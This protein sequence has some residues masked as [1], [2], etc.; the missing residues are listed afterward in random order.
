MDTNIIGS[1]HQWNQFDAISAPSPDA[2]RQGEELLHRDSGHSVREAAQQF[3][4]YFLSYLLKTMRETVPTGFLD[5]KG[6]QVWYSFYDQEIARL[7]TEAGGIGLSRF[8]EEHL[9]GK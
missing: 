2:L 4:T 8:I 7:A 9:P 6:E 5:R 1:L 3:E